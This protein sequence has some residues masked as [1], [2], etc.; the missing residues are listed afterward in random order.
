MGSVGSA[1]VGLLGLV[2]DLVKNIVAAGKDPEEELKKL[3][4]SYEIKDDVDSKVDDAAD[5]KF[6]SRD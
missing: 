3:A 5:A 1:V 6:G 4:K 2:V